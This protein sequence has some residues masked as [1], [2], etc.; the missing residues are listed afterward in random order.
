MKRRIL[1]SSQLPTPEEMMGEVIG[2]FFNAGY[3]MTVTD[4]WE[5]TCIAT[6]DADKMP[7]VEIVVTRE[8]DQDTINFD[9]NLTF[10]ALSTAEEQYYDS[11]HYYIE[12]WARVGGAVSALVKNSIHLSDWVDE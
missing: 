2:K 4:D 3:D 5:I 7:K 10:P 8:D 1:G 9:A 11:V 12:E 6:E